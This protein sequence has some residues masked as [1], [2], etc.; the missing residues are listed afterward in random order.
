MNHFSAYE[1]FRNIWDKIL[2]NKSVQMNFDDWFHG[3]VSARSWYTK[4]NGFIKTHLETQFLSPL[5]QHDILQYSN[6]ADKLYDSRGK[7]ITCGDI[8]Q[9]TSGDTFV[10]INNLGMARHTETNQF[11][12]LHRKGQVL[13]NGTLFLEL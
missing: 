9:Q 5:P 13:L 1:R 12:L 11:S 6:K 4:S 7:A 2:S 3:I 8:I 10:I